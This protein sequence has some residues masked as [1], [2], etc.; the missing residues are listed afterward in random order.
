[1]RIALLVGLLIATAACGPY[2]FPGGGS[3]TGNVHGQVLGLACGGPIQ[4]G[5]VPIQPGGAPCLAT[6]ISGCPPQPAGS[7]VCGELPLPG[8]ELAFTAGTS[9]L[10]TKTDSAGTYSIEL[11]AGPWN[12]SGATFGSIVDGPQPV[13][14]IAGESTIADYLVQTGIRAGA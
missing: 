8:F 7:Q 4:P 3:D 2:R 12:V 1:M 13:V 11:P 5:G 10:V 6:P 14:V 9:R